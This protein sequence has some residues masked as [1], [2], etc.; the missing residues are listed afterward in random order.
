MKLKIPHSVL[1]RIVD[2]LGRLCCLTHPFHKLEIKLFGNH[3]QLAL[4]SF[5]LDERWG[6]GWWVLDDFSEDD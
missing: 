5:R 1:K 2:L 6:T 3:C 4:L